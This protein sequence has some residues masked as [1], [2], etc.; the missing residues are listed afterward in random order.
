[1]RARASGWEYVQTWGG[2]VRHVMPHDDLLPHNAE[3]DCPCGIDM[4]WLYSE[5]GIRWGRL[6]KHHAYDKRMT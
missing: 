4:E 5:G 6:Y 3:L 1:M 2:R